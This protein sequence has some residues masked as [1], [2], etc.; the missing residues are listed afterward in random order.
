MATTKQPRGTKL[1]KRLEKLIPQPKEASV[2]MTG[3]VE[4]L[5]RIV[6]ELQSKKKKVAFW[7]KQ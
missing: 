4:E 1:T 6:Q 7:T 2:G 3:D 5:E